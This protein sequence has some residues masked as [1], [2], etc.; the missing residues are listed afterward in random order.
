MRYAAW[1]VALMAFLAV[2]KVQAE[3]LRAVMETD[4]ARWLEA[5]N[6]NKPAAFPTMYTEDAMLLPPGGE[7]V[8]GRQAIGQFWE[9]RLKPGNRKNHTF[10][11]V[12]IQQDGQLAY[13]IAEWT[14]LVTT[15]TGE[16]TKASGNTVRIFER[17]PGGEWLTK[18][19]IFNL[20]H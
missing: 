4:N 16:T 11:I 12:A 17:Q 7:P 5:Y 8:R 20:H 19:H 18:A 3:D 15:S 9:N 10:E 6:T 14:V 1:L 2:S 13:Q